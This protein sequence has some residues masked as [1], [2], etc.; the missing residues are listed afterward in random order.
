MRIKQKELIGK[1]PQVT[2]TKT[3]PNQLVIIAQVFDNPKCVNVIKKVNN[4]VTERQCYMLTDDMYHKY[5]YSSNSQVDDLFATK[6]NCNCIKTI[7]NKIRRYIW[8]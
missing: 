4:K 2:Y 7:W 1:I 3:L 8:N 5:I 6:S